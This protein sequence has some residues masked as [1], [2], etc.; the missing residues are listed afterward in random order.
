M[1]NQFAVKQRMTGVKIER[2]EESLWRK[3]DEK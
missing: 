1:R 3:E 2:K